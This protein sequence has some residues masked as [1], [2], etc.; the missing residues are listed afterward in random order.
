MIR[1]HLMALRVGLMVVDGLSA[2]AVFLLA[3]ILRFRDG[4]PE[5][6][7]RTIG[8]DVGVAAL[9][10]AVLW[11]AA[12]WYCGLYR[13]SVRWQLWSEG[14]DIVRATLLVA[15]ISLSGRPSGWARNSQW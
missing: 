12:L 7:W 5:Y 8:I 15:A 14:G 13:M 3:S 10:F 6:L 1:R 2:I 4:D 9:L 11:V